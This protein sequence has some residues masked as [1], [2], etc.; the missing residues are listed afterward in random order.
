MDKE[1]SSLKVSLQIIVRA[2][3]SLLE[4]ICSCR[5]AVQEAERRLD[6]LEHV[7]ETA[8]R[9]EVKTDGNQD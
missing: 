9:V 5:E 6:L 4:Y 2:P 8:F 3:E 1:Q 7:I